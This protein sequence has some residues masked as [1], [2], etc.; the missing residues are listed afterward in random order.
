MIRRPPRSTLFP[1]TTLFRSIELGQL[2]SGIARQEVRQEGAFDRGQRADRLQIASASAITLWIHARGSGDALVRNQHVAEFSAESVLS[3][4]DVAIEDDA[5]AVARPDD[6][7][8]GG[9]LAVGSEDRVVSPKRA[10]VGVVQIQHRLAEFAGEAFAD[11]KSCPL[12]MDE[13]GGA[14]R[15]Q[16][17]RSAGRSGSV[18]AVRNDVIDS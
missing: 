4:H 2:V 11:I 7:R 14:A 17:A 18:E 3:L 10:G 5:A 1:Y 15:T 6:D 13:V 16:H 12:G 8:D 9:L